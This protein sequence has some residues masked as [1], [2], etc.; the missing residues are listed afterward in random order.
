MTYPGQYPAHPGYPGSPTPPAP[1]G[2]APVTLADPVTMAGQ[3]TPQGRN[4]VNRT[5]AL[6]IHAY[7]PTNTYP[8]DTKPR[9]RITADVYVLDGPV[10][11][12]FGEGERP[13]SPPTHRVDVM[14]AFFP[15]CW[16]TGTVA[17]NGPTFVGTNRPLAGRFVQG[18]KALL[19]VRL[20]HDKLD[21]RAAE[22]PQLREALINLIT[23]HRSGQ[24]TPPA[25]VEINGGQ[26]PGAPT[27]AYP[28]QAAPA[29]PVNYGAPGV[30]QLPGVPALP[31]PPAA[32]YWPQG[33]TRELWDQHAPTMTPD[34]RAQW[35]AVPRATGF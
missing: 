28:G 6:V 5:V 16:L 20:G 3:K 11:L 31:Q 14:P 24:W 4:L 22:A 12:T 2:P 13:P 25:A 34:V 9:P 33:W 10:P 1:Q 29:G 27:Y 23:A 19:F 30:P 21:P 18:E 17:D 35:D 8:G 26:Q 32:P 15:G 7:D